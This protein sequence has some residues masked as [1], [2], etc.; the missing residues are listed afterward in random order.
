MG[1]CLGYRW[2]CS[3]ASLDLMRESISMSHGMNG[4]SRDA[5]VSKIWDET[6]RLPA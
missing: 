4:G 1:T 3:E 6:Y 2:A 5:N